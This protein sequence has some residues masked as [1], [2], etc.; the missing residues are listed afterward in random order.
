MIADAARAMPHTL[1]A[2]DGEDE[3]IAELEMI[4]GLRPGQRGNPGRE[5]AARPADPD[6][7]LAG[8]GAT[9]AVA[10][11]GSPHAAGTV[12]VSG[13]DPQGWPAAAGHPISAEGSEEGRA[14]GREDLRRPGRADSRRSRGP[15]PPR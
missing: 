2:I 9:A 14:A 7:S 11:P 13:P 6:P 10:A 12:R 8:T 4:V 3:T 5:P 1:R 15:R